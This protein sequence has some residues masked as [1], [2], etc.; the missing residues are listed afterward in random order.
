MAYPSDIETDGQTVC[1]PSLGVRI[2]FPQV[3]YPNGRVR[4]PDVQTT[5][6]EPGL[7]PSPN[8]VFGEKAASP[9]DQ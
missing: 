6:F 9:F 8:M 2:P 7:R 4:R 3:R 1:V 5:M